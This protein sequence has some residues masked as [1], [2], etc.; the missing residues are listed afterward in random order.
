MSDGRKRLSGAEYKKRSK[1][2]HEEQER[3]LKQTKKLDLFF[4]TSSLPVGEKEKT[5]KEEPESALPVCDSS[6]GDAID[7]NVI[8]GTS[9]S[10]TNETVTLSEIQVSSHSESEILSDT[11][12]VK[13]QS[14]KEFKKPTL[15]ISLDKDPAF[16]VL[17]DATRDSIAKNGFDQNVGLDFTNSVRV[18][19]DQKRYLTKSFFEGKLKNGEVYERKWMI[20]SK[21]KG[22]VFCGPCLAFNTKERSQFDDKDGFNDWKNGESRASHHQNSPIHKSAVI[23]LKARGLTL[24]RVDNML[25]LQLDKETHYWRNVLTRV[26]AAVKALTSRGLA[27]RGDNEIFGSNRNGNFLM[28]LELMSEFDP[29]LAS[30]IAKYGNCGSGNT[31]YLS[32]KTCDEVIELMAQKVRQVICEELKQS[33]YYSLIVDSTPDMSHVDQLVL[34]VRYVLSS[35][36]PCERFL[37]FIPSAGHSAEGMFKSV[38]NELENLQINIVDCRGQSYDNA[39]NMSGV[40]NGLQAKI[41]T[42]SPLALFIPCA[43]HSLNLVGLAAA[44]SCEEACTFFMLLQEIYVFFTCSTKRWECLTSVMEES[45]Q[46]N[47]TIKKLCPTRWSARDDACQSLRESWE[48]VNTALMKISNDTTEKA[49]TRCESRGILRRLERFETAFMVCFWSTVLH[50][51]HKVSKAMQS[52]TVDVLLVRDL[53]GSLEE[54]FMEQRNH[55]DSFETLATDISK[56]V[57]YEKDTKRQL[58][59]KVWP[60][61]DRIGEVTLPGRDNLKIN[62]FLPIIDSFVNEFKK[63]KVAYEE[64]QDR[65]YFLTQLCDEKTDMGEEL[66]KNATKLYQIYN[67]DLDSDLIEECIHF[68]KHCAVGL[69]HPSEKSLEGISK[70]LKNNS[71]Q[72][73]YPNLDIAIRISLCIPATNCAGE[74]SFSCLRRVKNYLRTSI[75]ELR[76]NSLSL[77]CIE[78]N[79]TK[80]LSYKDIINEFANKKSRRKHCGVML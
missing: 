2:K 35:G 38:L 4:K 72:D 41:K 40:Y 34:A 9:R 3:V 61:E 78:A 44:E 14:L 55:F 76:L 48:Q 66:R 69:T 25:T 53:Y 6:D 49:T 71:L 58:K 18:Y 8:A 10:E 46:N 5:D 79:T 42:K 36:E 12:D 64:F 43:A 22:S 57:S 37:T 23:T 67:N 7:A 17:N 20:Y 62:T 51:I 29:F 30:H 15:A 50:R 63:R 32:S 73:V 39:S 65:F 80:T 52:G 31:N 77:L 24:N 19:K 21:S 28:V 60:D 47:K 70:F 26:V 45:Y 54:Y 1:L 27:L 75:S 13:S 68:K 74:R 16:W 56:T 11:I 33:K 59:R